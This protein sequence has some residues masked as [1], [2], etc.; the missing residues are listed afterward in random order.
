MESLLAETFLDLAEKLRGIDGKGDS[1]QFIMIKGATAEAGEC[2]WA[3]LF[4][5][6]ICLDPILFQTI[7]PPQS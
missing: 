6:I 3:E 4:D 5:A 1:Y 7:A 2:G